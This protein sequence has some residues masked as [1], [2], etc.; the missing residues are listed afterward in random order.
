MNR[1][2]KLSGFKYAKGQKRSAALTTEV[3]VSSAPNELGAEE[4]RE[5]LSDAVV[6]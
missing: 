5:K 6:D 4:V 2:A 1:G 3:I